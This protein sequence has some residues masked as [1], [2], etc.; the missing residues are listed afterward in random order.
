MHVTGQR[1]LIALAGLLLLIA[2]GVA[3]A[4]KGGAGAPVTGALTL[5]RQRAS[6]GKTVQARLE[7]AA[8]NDAPRLRLKIGALDNCAAESSP[9]TPALVENVKKGSVIHVVARFKVTQAT[10]CVLFAEV[11]AA[12]GANYR[13]ASVFDATL[14]A[15]PPK[16]D[17]TR[18]GKTGADRPTAHFTSSR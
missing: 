8:F 16:G 7:I 11:V 1:G 9:A 13:F 12:E 18:P 5:D 2:P 4:S 17:N 3:S 6:V 15:G 14:N 10:P